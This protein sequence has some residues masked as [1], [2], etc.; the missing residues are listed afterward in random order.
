MGFIVDEKDASELITQLEYSNQAHLLELVET[1]RHRPLRSFSSAIIT[2]MSHNTLSQQ[3]EPT[4][5]IMRASLLFLFQQINFKLFKE[6]SAETTIM[7]G[8]EKGFL[9]YDEIGV[10]FTN[11]QKKKKKPT[12]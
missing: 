2:G 11:S 9:K 5:R 6:F 4:T 7:L 10:K 8:L 1:K 12:L 3:H